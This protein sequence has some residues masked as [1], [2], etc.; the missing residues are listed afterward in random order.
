MEHE[1]LF[2]LINRY[3]LT[4]LIFLKISL[5]CFTLVSHVLPCIKIP[6]HML[7]VKFSKIIVVCRSFHFLLVISFC[8]Y[9][10]SYWNPKD[11]CKLVLI[12]VRVT[13]KKDGMGVSRFLLLDWPAKLTEYYQQFQHRFLLNSTNVWISFCAF[14]SFYRCLSK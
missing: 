1:I 11:Y 13:I 4:F 12:N 6:L 8:H 5:V 9:I 14:H 7:S 10:I 2:S 3:I